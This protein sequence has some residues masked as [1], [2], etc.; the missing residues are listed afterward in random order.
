MFVR[1]LV[2]ISGLVLFSGACSKNTG[3][4]NKDSKIVARAGDEELDEETYRS[5]LINTGVVKDSAFQGKRFIDKWAIESLFYQEAISKLNSEEMQIEKQVQEYRQA[6][7][8]HIYQ[9]KVIEANLDTVINPDEIESYYE[10]HRD[11]FILKDNIVKVNY[12]K[13]AE[14]SP[15]LPK[16]RKL[17]TAGAEK[18]RSAL[19]ELCTQNAENFF[20]DDSTWLFVDDLKK[21]IPSLRDHEE[22]TFTSGRVLEFQEEGFYYYLKV[23][24]VKTKNSF[25]PLNFEV[26]NIRKF[27]LNNRKTQ[28]IN[29]YKQLLLEKAKGSNKYVIY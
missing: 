9:T 26:Q 27:I 11:N 24:D 12:L 5:G 13:I 2:I 19:R 25:S 14:K 29:Q 18:D 20:L 7:V 3:A 8:N 17:L 6:L 23:K 28:L 4:E 16:I 1:H 15:A 10:D 22:Y 21:E